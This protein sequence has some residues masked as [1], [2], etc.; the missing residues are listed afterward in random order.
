MQ[1][2]I[3]PKSVNLVDLVLYS[4]QE[5]FDFPGEIKYFQGREVSGL[6]CIFLSQDEYLKAQLKGPAEDVESIVF[7]RSGRRIFFWFCDEQFAFRQTGPN[8]WQLFFYYDPFDP[9]NEAHRQLDIQ[10][11]VGDLKN[12]F[13]DQSITSYRSQSKKKAS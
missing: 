13:S 11:L 5:H 4:T 9:H 10:G 8:K 1:N 3:R 6:N 2:K 12:F 7:F